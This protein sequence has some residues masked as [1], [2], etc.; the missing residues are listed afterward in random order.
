[1]SIKLGL[2][3]GGYWGK[4]LIHQFVLCNVLHTICEINETANKQYNELY[5]HVH[6][7]VKWTDILTNDE[8]TA[9]CISL[10][11]DMH[12]KFAK[13][14]LLANKDV[15]VEKPITLKIEEA[16]ELA[17]LAKEKNKILMVGH[18]LQYHPCIEKIMELVK[19]GEIGKIKNIVSN[20]L[21]LGIFRTQENVM[22]SFAPHDISVIL[23]LCNDKLPDTIQCN[24]KSVLTK[25][26]HDITNTIMKYDDDD[27]YVNINVN[28]LNPFKE[29]KLTVIGEHGM[30][31]FDDM[32]VKDKVK[33][34][35]NYI[36]WNN[37]VPM[38]V[39]TDGEVVEVKMEDSPLLLECKHF[40]ECCVT[41][42]VPRTNGE[43]GVRVLQ[44]LTKSQESLEKNGEVVKVGSKK[45]DYY[46][47]PTAIVDP[48]AK[49]GRSTRI[50]HYSHICSTA[51]IGSNCNIGQNAYIA[52]TLGDGCKVQN[53]VSV[54]SGVE[55]GSNVFVG[56]SVV[57]TND[58]LPLC[59]YSKNGVYVKTYIEN[60]VSI[61]ANSTII[62]GV[63]IGHHSFIA[64]G[65]TICKNVDPHSLMMTDIVATKRG[66]IDEFGN[67]TYNK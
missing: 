28:W 41:R 31:V 56:P 30:I 18:L 46:V 35:K 57:F 3:G 66:T 55:C 10:P 61:G 33:I 48:G 21:N 50:W 49:I 43:E 19:G 6:T 36:I 59:K 5:P 17:E 60:A 11:A 12:Y 42:E 63:R 45:V 29:Q 20:R 22:W 51:I 7:T 25:G 40:I 16:E 32:Q 2:I 53:N 58:K 15:Y 27:V 67:I 24:G 26:I 13:D 52:G 14:A 37:E 65:S 54:Y 4:R 47:H 39:K 44:V 9:V 34:Y 8:I 38:P 1:M 23:S 64:A 62:C